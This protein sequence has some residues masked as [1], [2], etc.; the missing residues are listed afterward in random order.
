MGLL[1][2]ICSMNW[3]FDS[4]PYTIGLFIISYIWAMFGIPP[5]IPG[6]PPMPPIPGIPPI[7]P[8]IPGIPPIPPIIPGMPPM[9]PKGLAPALGWA[10]AEGSEELLVG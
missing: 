6:I 5:P 2:I 1:L 7:P 4:I 3:G 8:I 10:V 9:A